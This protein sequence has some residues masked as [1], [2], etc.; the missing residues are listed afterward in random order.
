[1][2]LISILR[3]NRV[4]DCGRT[5]KALVA[6]VIMLLRKPGFLP[7]GVTRLYTHS[8]SQTFVFMFHESSRTFIFGA[9]SM[10]QILT[11]AAPSH[12][13]APVELNPVNPRPVKMAAP[14]R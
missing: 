8:R 10:S 6:K 1:M 12:T 13:V 5:Q 4:S 9:N 3:H 14:Y 11:F 2:G 7:A